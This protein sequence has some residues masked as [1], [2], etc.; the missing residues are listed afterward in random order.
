MQV[1][2]CSFS[3]KPGVRIIIWPEFRIAQ[4]YT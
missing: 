3:G 4:R 1:V 2:S